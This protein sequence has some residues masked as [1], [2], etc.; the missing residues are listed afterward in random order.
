[1]FDSTIAKNISVQFLLVFMLLLFTARFSLSRV[2]YKI[3][4]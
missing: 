2:F 3:V 4:N 1:M